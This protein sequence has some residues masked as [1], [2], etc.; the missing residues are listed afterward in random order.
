MYSTWIFGSFLLIFI[1]TA[2]IALSDLAGF[3]KIT[4]PSAKKWV[5]NGLLAQVAGVIVSLASVLLIDR[6]SD[7]WTVYGKISLEDGSPNSHIQQSIVSMAPPA[8][9]IDEMGRFRANIVIK[10][11]SADEL[12]FP[13]IQVG[14][15]GFVTKTIYINN[16]WEGI[17][18]EVAS[19]DIKIDRNNKTITIGTPINLDAIRT[20]YNTSSSFSV[21]PTALEGDL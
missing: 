5:R 20:P 15:P 2:L 14:A 21:T 18:G 19:E 7:A 12:D 9:E 11:I 6:G 16:K 1:A 3:I 10:K 8:V 13:K 17:E 4:D